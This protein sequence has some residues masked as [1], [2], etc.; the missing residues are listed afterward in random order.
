MTAA[1]AVFVLVLALLWTSTSARS[2]TGK[3]PVIA[4]IDMQR[5]QSES[6]A[7]QTMEQELNQRRSAFQGELQRKEEELRSTDQ[8]LA[9]QRAILSAEAYAKKRQDL[10]R[11]VTETR[12]EIQE[13]RKAL[14]EAYGQGMRQVRLRLL[15]IVKRIAEE[16]GAD[17]VLAKAQ[18]VLVRPD[19]EITQEA[20]DRL[21][22]ELPRI[23]TPVPQN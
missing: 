6:V 16:R 8:E 17:L 14:D 23:A 15:G 20:L 11:Q 7:I 4:I 1:V 10:E 21:N 13:R 19:L 22:V 12:R 3:S 5:I 18:V 9:R 2:Q